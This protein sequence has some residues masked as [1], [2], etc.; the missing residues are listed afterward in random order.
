MGVDAAA[1]VVCPFSRLTAAA[2][3]DVPGAAA[4]GAAAAFSSGILVSFFCL[5]RLLFL[6]SS[7][8]RGFVDRRFRFI[9]KARPFPPAPRAAFYLFIYE[10][11]ATALATARRVGK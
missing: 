3:G 2:V 5:A 10:A 4:T 11:A 6:Q 8:F 1:V 9:N 7:E